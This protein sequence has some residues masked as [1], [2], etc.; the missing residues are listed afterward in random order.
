M[1]FNMVSVPYT[2]TRFLRK[3]LDENHRPPVEQMHTYVAAEWHVWFDGLVVCPM[4]DPMLHAIGIINREHGEPR[5]SDFELLAS[6]ANAGTHFFCIDNGD[7]AGE[8][9]RLADW[10]GVRDPLV[11][12]WA[13]VGQRPDRLGWRRA[14]LE[15]GVLPDPGWPH[16]VG[17]GTRALLRR[18]GYERDWL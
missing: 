18:L 6:L 5:W 8:V 9:E 11:V 16:Q 7:P 10:L 15:D 17:D 1:P 4:R 3:I 14:Y 2:G 12:D 13:P